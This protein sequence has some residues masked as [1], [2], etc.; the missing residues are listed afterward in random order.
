MARKYPFL[1][2][3]V[4]FIIYMVRALV[5][6][7]GF[8]VLQQLCMNHNTN[9]FVDSTCLSDSKTRALVSVY[10]TA[11][12]YLLVKVVFAAVNAYR[13]RVAQLQRGIEEG[14]Y[15]HCPV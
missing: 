11:S 3:N 8:L 14:V 9:S 10:L 13:Y 12:G 7:A 6:S 4:A 5:L 15:A 1:R 2:L